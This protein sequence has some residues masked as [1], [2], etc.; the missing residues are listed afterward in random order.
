MK[1]LINGISSGIAEV[2]EQ[3]REIGDLVLGRIKGYLK[4]NRLLK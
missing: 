4:F 1:G 2:M 3:V